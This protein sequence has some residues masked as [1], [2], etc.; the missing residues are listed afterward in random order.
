LDYHVRYYVAHP[1]KQKETDV[2]ERNGKLHLTLKKKKE[3]L[4]NNIYG[5]DIDFQA[6]EVTQL[7]LYLKLL[8]DVT[9]HDAHQF[10]LFKETILPDLRQNI[11]CGNSLVGSDIMYGQLFATINETKLKPMNFED[12]FP[13]V[14]KRGGFDAV[15]GNPPYVRIQTLNESNPEAVEYFGKKY[16]SS[17]SG[18]YDIYV[19]FVEQALQK[20]NKYGRLGYILP[21]KF[22]N[23]QY[24]IGIRT[25]L[26]KGKH[27]SGVVHFGAN[28]VFSGATTYTCLLFLTKWSNEDFH[29]IKIDNIERWRNNGTCTDGII[30]CSNVNAEEWNFTV[31]EN[32]II[33]DKLKNFVPKLNDCADIFVGLQTSAD[34]VFI[35]DLVEETT[36]SI[37]LKSESLEKNWTFEKDLLFPLVSGTDVKRYR[38]LNKRQYII[39]PYSVKSG[40][41][42]LIPF[43]KL[44]KA[45]PNT[46]KYLI[47]NKKRL[48]N[49]EHGKFK[50]SE[51]YRFG[52]NQNIGIQNRIKL[53]VPRL[54][55]K[56][57]C[58]IDPNGSYYLD[59]VDVGG[60]SLKQ[61][62]QN[63][64]LRYILAL[65]NSKLLQWYFPN[66]SAP[67]R[68][69]WLS[70]NKQF[71]GQLPIRKIDFS[72][73]ADKA[74]H[75]H[76]VKFVE[77]M[78]ET[79]EKLGK[80]KTEAET[81]R[82][83]M[84][85][86]KLDRQIDEAVYGLYGLTEEEIKIV[87]GK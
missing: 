69:G 73:S 79:K 75:D 13:N 36:S 8:E 38:I 83:E 17:Q 80:A 23:A 5:V 41:I 31:G 58:T 10:G 7:S 44:E 46:A 81:D 2:I 87:E 16:I 65:I 86:E 63:Y 19:V 30:S 57:G 54:V 24:G 59:N 14:M 45:Y 42:E 77:Q 52:R 48:E 15:V 20:L 34:D 28:Q 43:E 3:I 11:V 47:E 27:L 51:W 53:C 85:C 35:L 25:L 72:D 26:S 12:A 6:T 78:L 62:F 22:F 64:N 49:R 74:R 40:I 33:Y 37:K 76:I 70:A 56:L 21:H 29:F 50:D 32:A 18:S 1:D 60:V 84:Q 39:F 68:G 66:I 71:L 82:L 67:F 9:M 4:L 55:E 61:E